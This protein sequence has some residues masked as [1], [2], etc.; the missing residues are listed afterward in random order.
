MQE[1]RQEDIRLFG[2]YTSPSASEKDWLYI[3]VSPKR[4]Y[5][6]GRNVFVEI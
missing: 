1:V 2:V 4:C 3:I 6:G 5:K